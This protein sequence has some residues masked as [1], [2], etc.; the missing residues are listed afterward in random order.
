M[1]VIILAQKD[2]YALQRLANV[3][4]SRHHDLK[5]ISPIDCT[6]RTDGAHAEVIYYNQPLSADVVLLRCIAYTWHGVTIMRAF[7]T[8][9]A[10]QLKLNGAVCINDPEAKLRAHDKFLTVQVLNNAGI[11]VPPTFLTWDETNVESI[12]HNHLGF[13][14]ILKMTEGTWGV[15]VTKADS[16]ESARSIFDTIKGMARVFTLQK[17]EAEAKGQDIRVFVL[18]K[19]VIGA[20]RRTAQANDFRSNIHQGGKA[21]SVI[22]PSGYSDIAIRATDV[23]GLD[24]AGVDMLE[25]SEGPKVIEVNP[26]PGFES[27]ESATDVDVAT[28]IVQYL[29]QKVKY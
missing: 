19:K 14:L 6:V 1:K 4:T 9:V 26:S 15:G 23:M 24:M 28:Q 16:L 2:S 10:N 11:P 20:I 25:T 3:I 29:E 17:Y 18:G 13:P 22:L 12:A 7:E 21:E 8:Y 5:I 27:I